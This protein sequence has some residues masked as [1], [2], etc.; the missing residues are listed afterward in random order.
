MVTLRL[1]STT[2]YTDT[3]RDVPALLRVARCVIPDTDEALNLLRE[4]ASRFEPSDERWEGQ[5]APLL[6]PSSTGDATN[7]QHDTVLGKGSTCREVIEVVVEWTIACSSAGCTIN[8]WKVRE[9]T[10]L[11]CNTHN[12][13]FTGGGPGP[14]PDPCGEQLMPTA[15]TEAFCNGG[16]DEV[17]E[18]IAATWGKA[19]KLLNKIRKAIAAGEDLSDVATWR[20]MLAEEW[21]TVAGCAVGLTTGSAV[22]T[23]MI[24]CALDL[25]VG[26]KGDDLVEFAKF[27]GHLDEL[28]DLA[29]GTPVFR[30]L[31]ES[32]G[33]LDNLYDIGRAYPMQGDNFFIPDASGLTVFNSI[34]RSNSI[35]P[36]P[37]SSAGG[38]GYWMNVNGTRINYYPLSSSEP[39]RPTIEVIG[40]IGPRTS[41]AKYRFDLP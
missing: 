16:P 5:P 30:Y 23:E 36:T 7:A 8:S 22:A 35:S 26:F 21:D 34:A 27:S 19:A 11:D 14:T 28:I 12:D 24:N 41:G 1:S 10:K 29:K 32:V 3:P 17:E 4:Q 39:R 37:L 40:P 31:A 2:H 15:D 13:P 9:V 33:S 25:L 20:K 38:T 6:N 18:A